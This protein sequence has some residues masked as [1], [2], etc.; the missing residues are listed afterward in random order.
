V[1]DRRITVMGIFVADLA[2]RSRTLPAW[3]QTVLGAE[4]RLSPGGKGSNQAVAAARLGVPVSLVAKIGR[5]PFGA[6]ARETWAAEG[7][8]TRFCFEAPEEPSGAAAIVVHP[9]SGENAIVVVPGAS[10][11]L[12]EAEVDLAA[13]LIAGSAAFVVQLEVPL[14]V[15]E[16]AL[17]LAR[18]RG[19]LTILNAA[20]ARRLPRRVYSLCDV[21]TPNEVE[22]AALTGR[23]VRTRADAER[24]ADVLLGRGA[25][26]VV[27]TLGRRGAFAK[28]AE[29][30]GHVPAFHAGPAVETTG[31]GDAFTGALAVALAEGRDLVAAT[32][33]ACA[34]GAVSVTRH[35]TSRSM[36]VRSEVEALLAARPETSPRARA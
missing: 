28:N 27:I 3:G 1:T 26:N 16:H 30:A 14:P 24:A 23:P 9:A 19:V 10:S 13:E 31:A 21:L 4:Y 11:A 17:A 34:A 20:P 12:T 32:R 35:G 6:L 5:D 7:I 29:G 15:V 22:A 2:F 25:R 36:P 8:D 18:G 33:F